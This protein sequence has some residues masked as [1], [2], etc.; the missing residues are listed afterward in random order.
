M[1]DDET[2]LRRPPATTAIWTRLNRAAQSVQAQVETRLKAAGLPPL[3][4]YDVLWEIEKSGDA[5][6]RPYAL[7]DRLLLPQ[8]GLSRLAERLV[9]E[10]LVLRK[11]D[12]ED[13]RGHLLAL[14]GKGR[15]L[16]AAM[17][18]VYAN[19][20][21]DAVGAKLSER[22]ALVLADLLDRLAPK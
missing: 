13:G 15:D 1:T 20:L 9:Q 6:I 21:T 11:P 12:A 2:P 7:Q 16:R 17:W 14:T 19:A 4:W 8:Y 10:G 18:P 5:G 3:T 22:E